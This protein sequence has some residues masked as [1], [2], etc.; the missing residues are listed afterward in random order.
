MRKFITLLILLFKIQKKLFMKKALPLIIIA[1][2]AFGRLAAQAI[3]DGNFNTWNTTT[4]SDPQ[5][6]NTSNDQDITQY[7]GSTANVL[8]VA[9]WENDVNG[10]KLTT[11][12]FGTDTLVGYMTNSIGNPLQGIGGIAYNQ[13]P[14]GIEFW[15]NC[16]IV[17]GDSGGVGVWFKKGGV[18]M[19]SYLYGIPSSKNTSSYPEFSISFSPAL[20]FTP[21][22]VIVAAVSSIEALRNKSGFP[23][24]T[25]TV[26]GIMFLG[27]SQP[28]LLNGNFTSWVTDTAFSPQGWTALYPGASRTKDVYSGTYALELQTT[29]G[30]G[31]KGKSA[32]PGFA[33]TGRY[34]S[35]GNK[36]DSIVGGYPYTKDSD[37]LEFYYKYTPATGS[38]DSGDVNME[39]KKSG[40]I[41]FSSGTTLTAASSYTHFELPF[42]FGT[43]PDS[44]IVSFYSSFSDTGNTPVADIGSTLLVDD[45]QFESQPT[46][47]KPVLLANNSIL[48]YPNPASNQLTINCD[49][50]SINEIRLANVL[51]QTLIE[52]TYADGISGLKENIDVSNLSSGLYFITI[53]SGN[54]TSTGKIMV[55]R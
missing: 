25:F 14:T 54:T 17:S 28:A 39:F 21:D 5:Y 51:G 13:E 9:G 37:I 42:N 4:W 55:N 18:I 8:E 35:N 15:Y 52:K 24:S 41:I 12:L 33:T 34:T 36:E 43:A 10:V 40:A 44:V 7:P 50:L 27:A 53:T 47:I 16:N 29:N 3:P 1:V 26:S 46:G 23:N 31:D 19:A 2:F 30:G 45:V 32:Q 20:N 22:T 38:K 48:I 6:Y 49:Q 11:Q